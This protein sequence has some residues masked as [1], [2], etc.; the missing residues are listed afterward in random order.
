MKFALI[1][2]VAA[3]TAIKVQ[4]QCVSMKQSN[5]VF[6]IV[7]RNHDGQISRGELRSAMTH[8]LD[9]HPRA[10]REANK[11]TQA[12]VEHLRTMVGDAAGA[13]QRLNPAEF[14]S[15]ANQMCALYEAEN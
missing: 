11:L 8:Y 5:G 9:S 12:D 2:L 14:N 15:L 1:A 10:A 6:K 7:D 13:D 3:A 4:D